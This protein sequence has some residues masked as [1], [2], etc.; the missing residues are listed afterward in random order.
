[1]AIGAGRA[2]GLLTLADCHVEVDCGPV[3]RGR[4]LVDLRRVTGRD[5]NVHVAIDIDPVFNEFM[6]DRIASLG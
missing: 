2:A 5:P 3:S 6:A 1:M 4:T